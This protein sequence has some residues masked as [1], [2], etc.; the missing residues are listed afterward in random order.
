[1]KKRENRKERGEGKTEERG[2]KSKG[3]GK[4]GTFSNN[5]FK[6]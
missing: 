2:E 6:L 5:V 1:M 4:I 3:G